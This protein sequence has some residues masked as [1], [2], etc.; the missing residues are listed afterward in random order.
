M[1]APFAPPVPWRR[2]L[3]VV[4]ALLVL[5]SA[6]SFST[7]WPTP[8]IVPEARL[9]PEF[10]GL[11][12]LLLVLVWR[13][14]YLGRRG[15]ALLT[16]GYLLL[17]LGRYADVTTPSLFG[18][19]INLYWDGLQI[20]RFLWV[21]SQERPWWQTAAVVGGTGLLLWLMFTVLRSAMTVAA[22]V[23]APY[24]LSR[25]WALGLSAALGALAVANLAGVQATWPYVSKPVIP[26]YVKQMQ[27][28][29]NA[30]SEQR[31]ATLLPASTA[32]SVAMQNPLEALAGLKGRDVYLMPMESVGAITYDNPVAHA[33]L[34]PVREQFARDVAAN[35]QQV[36]SAFFKSPTFGGGTDLAQLG[37]LT[38][39]N[40]S[41]PMAHDVLLTT[42]RPTLMSLFKA[43]GFATFGVYP[44]VFWEWPERAFY[45]YD[46][47]IDG[48]RLGYP[49][50]ELGYWKI[51]DQFSV[52]RFEQMHPRLQGA[53]PRF[54]FF[55]T[56][57]CHLPFSPVPP[58]QPDWRRVLTAQPFD[59]RDTQQAL[60]EQPDWLNMFPDYVRMVAYTY[61][62]L[63]SHL[64]EPQA[65]EAI[66]LFVGDHQPAANVTGA[67]APWDVPVH[68]VSRD[69]ALLARFKAQGFQDGMAPARQ[70]LAELHELTGMMLKAFAQPGTP[71]NGPRT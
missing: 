70:P 20:P 53:Q 6:L 13:R 16:L 68:I 33:A 39:I 67:G 26:T 8:G 50:P 41:N 69:P 63:G 24:A 19:E 34:S 56:I 46:V 57:T 1:P 54:V 62:V 30:L 4:L 65:R 61:R 14:A 21:S 5:N 7:W 48:P 49:G 43:A 17:V 12:L 37:L 71:L 60:N 44:G 45:N 23:A 28:I 36:V 31:Q 38:G 15:I 35:G 59:E 40:L 51:P 55:P 25:R 47:F 9:A 27:V 29:T 42:S 3:R 18:R 11:W 22:R 66:Y 2:L 32:V 64:R 10:V 52:A 58:F